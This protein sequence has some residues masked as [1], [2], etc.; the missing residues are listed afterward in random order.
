MIRKIDVLR[1]MKVPILALVVFFFLLNVQAEAQKTID[2]LGYRISITLPKTKNYSVVTIKKG[3]KTLAV[4]REGLAQDYG[5]SA[6]LISLLGSG[7]KQ[8]VIS[9]YT[10]GNH[11]CNPYWIYELTPEFRLLFRSKDFETIGYSDSQKLFQNIDHD[12]DMEIVDNTPA[13]HYFDDLAFVS[14]P[15]PTLIFD[16][17]HR[18]QK[19]EFANRKFRSFLLGDVQKWI[20]NANNVKDS[21]QSQFAVSMFTIFLDYVYA[22]KKDEGLKFYYGNEKLKQLQLAHNWKAVNKLLKSEPAY[23][24]LYRK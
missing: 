8:I 4:H 12:A 5:S 21:D 15:V 14:S 10:G 3:R 7:K 6:E 2:Y 17:N 24:A 13:F 20:S 22:G 19:F 11:C 23:K 1:V 9:Q 16:Y 18:T